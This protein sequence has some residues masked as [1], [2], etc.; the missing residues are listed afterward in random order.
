MIEV[1]NPELRAYQE[2]RLQ[3]LVSENVKAPESSIVFVGDSITE[4]FPLK[5][6]LGRDLPLLNRGIAGTDTQWLLEHMKEQTL[7]VMPSKLFL[8]IGVNDIGKG[9]DQSE[10]IGNISELLNQIRINTY[11]SEIF[12]ISILPVNEDVKYAE[13][14]KMRKNQVIKKVNNQLNEFL[15]VEFVDLYPILLDE[16]EQLSEIYTTDGLH[17]NQDGYEKIA[18]ALKPYL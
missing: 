8:M 11:G 6:Y 10:I 5:K 15:G 2:N 16:E 17:L 1:V 4:F 3:Q 7:S 18:E 12:L 9:R 13:K 14:V